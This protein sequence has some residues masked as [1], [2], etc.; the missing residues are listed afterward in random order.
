[1]IH[2]PE[3]FRAQDY[4]D[5]ELVPAERTAFEA[6]LAGC[7]DCRREVAIYRAVLGEIAALETWDPGPELTE[8]VL[9]EVLPAR[10]TAWVPALA[11]GAAA[12]VV[13]SL[14]AI[15]AAVSL[16]APRAWVSTLFA[17]ATRSL[18]DSAVFVLKSINAGAV[19]AFDSVGASNALLA[20]L[21][22][23]LRAIATSVSQPAVAATLWAALLA[24]VAVL[25]WMR[26]HEDRAREEDPHVGL[27]GL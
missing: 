21:S 25:W 8:R 18:V 11:W 17:E 13:A 14:G 5:G 24:G 15:A 2:C 16:P 6:H 3:S 26:P 22:P 19:R 1:M 20:R 4:L 23:L 9:A 7:A 12:S 10:R 27:L